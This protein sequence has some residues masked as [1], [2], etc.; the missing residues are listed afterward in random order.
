MAGYWCDNNYIKQLSIEYEKNT[1]S[2]IR[3][4]CKNKIVK[5]SLNIG[6]IKMNYTRFIF[7]NSIIYSHEMR[8]NIY[9]LFVVSLYTCSRVISM[10]LLELYWQY[11]NKWILT[12]PRSVV[13]NE[14]KCSF[15][16]ASS[17]QCHHLKRTRIS[18]PEYYVISQT[19]NAPWICPDYEA[20]HRSSF[21]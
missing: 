5:W 13:W 6:V 17:R 11:L 10:Y 1:F 21:H 2:G 18:M 19:V 12:Y 14:A 9:I 16:K 4:Y 15:E 7:Y 3:L 8:P 20:R